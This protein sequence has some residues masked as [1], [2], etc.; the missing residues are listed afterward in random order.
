MN[1]DKATLAWVPGTDQVAVLRHPIA[2]K[3]AEQFEC[4]FGSGEAMWSGLTTAGQ[5]AA[6]LATAIDAIALDG[7][8]AKA[9]RAVLMTVDELRGAFD[10]DA[11]D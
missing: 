8:D 9:V 4:M 3:M 2:P 11:V 10:A 1:L 7:V 5:A 6:M